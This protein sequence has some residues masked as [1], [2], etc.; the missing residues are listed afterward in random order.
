MK[1]KK[2]G[3]YSIMG[4]IYKIINQVNQKI[5][6]GQTSKTIQE[7]FKEH[8]IDSKKESLKN[9]PL[10]RAI[11]KY[12]FDKF[13]IE[14]VEECDNNELSEREIFWINYYNSYHNGY[15]A[16]LGGEGKNI[17]N[18]EE[19]KEYLIQRK[20]VKEICEI[21][22]CCP[23]VIYDVAKIFNID[24]KINCHRNFT[25]KSKQVYQYSKDNIFIQS[26]SSTADAAKWLFNNNKCAA[27]TS[28]VRS[29]ISEAANGKRKS[30]YGYFWKYQ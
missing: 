22:G 6:I 12:G 30:A 27:L 19:I 13:T 5:Y 1:R 25:E 11:N 3:A 21:I 9:R 7:R 18:Y 15:N 10:Y 17:Y 8:L 4:Y 28:G 16:T 24:L 26:F 20:S 29:H 2:E 14:L 23:D